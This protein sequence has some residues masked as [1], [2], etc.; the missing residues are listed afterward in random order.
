MCVYPFDALFWG[1]G[2]GTLQAPLF[3]QS[4]ET[5]LPAL[6]D[7]NGDGLPDL[8]LSNDSFTTTMLNSGIVSFSPTT[9]RLS[10]PAQLVNTAS[11]Q[12]TL[13]LKNNGENTLS[14]GSIKT[15]GPF[16]VKDGCGSRLASGAACSLSVEFKPTSTGTAAGLIT[17]SDSASSK[18][19]FVD[20]SGSATVVKVAPASLTFSSE[21]IGTR[22]APQVVT[23]TNEGKTAISPKRVLGNAARFRAGYAAA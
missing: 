9:A 11:K 22:S 21:S 10:F 12:Q 6:G 16:A 17:I 3:L 23:A 15:A 4:G 14:I 18:P 20:L 2:D 13:S 1:N 19:Q 7:F 8:A 5:G